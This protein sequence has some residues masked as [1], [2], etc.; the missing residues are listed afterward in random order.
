MR[1]KI[2][3]AAAAALCAGCNGGTA[4][5]FSD[6]APCVADP[7]PTD[8][9]RARI[10]RER[11]VASLIVDEDLKEDRVADAMRRVPR[12]A[13]IPDAPLEEAYANLPLPIGFDQTISQPAVV[14]IMTEVCRRWLQRRELESGVSEARLP[15]FDDFCAHSEAPDDLPPSEHVLLDTTQPR[16]RSLSTLDANLDTSPNGLVA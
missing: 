13:F 6:A 7:K 2:A 16:E 5:L 4:V 1:E 12:D 10:L 15:I 11:L 14:A 3:N 9:S 8:S